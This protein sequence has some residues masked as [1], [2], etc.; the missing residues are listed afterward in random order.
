M[1]ADSGEPAPYR[2]F[3]SYSHVDSE[4]AHW[5][6]RKLENY[7]L[8]GADTVLR[9][10]FIDSAEL[11]A[12]TDLTEQVR[13]ALGRSAALIVAAS[14]AAHG[15]R[16]VAQEIEL[17]RELHPD[18]PILIAL[19]EGEPEQAFP[20]V[21][22]SRGGAAVEPLAADFRRGQDG[23]RLGLLKL[24][25][26]LTGTPL[27]R[28][29][30]RDGQRRQ[31]RVMA[32]TA[33]TM[34][35]SLIL[36]ALLL[37]AIRARAEAERR[38]AETEGMVEFMLTDLRQKLESVGRLDI[39]GA[40]N[41]RAMGHYAKER[42]LPADTM[43][44][45]ARLLAAMGEDDLTKTG[46]AERG[47]RE[48]SQAYRITGDLLKSDP[49]NPERIYQHA[50]SEHW[51]GYAAYLQQDKVTA[52]EH[53]LAYRA[54]IE[55]LVRVTID[56]QKWQREVAY[57]EGDLCAN[58]LAPPVEHAKALPHC[59]AA[60]E[61]MED[62]ALANP[63]NVETML[64]LAN[65]YAWQADALSGIGKHAEALALRERQKEL[66][67]RAVATA[68]LDAQAKEALMRAESGLARVLIQLSRDQDASAAADRAASIA[69]D[70]H[71]RDPQNRN[72]VIWKASIPR[73]R[74]RVTP[75][76]QVKTGGL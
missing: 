39:M 46:A 2:A 23:R 32:V 12:G 61:A 62:V 57:A 17:F 27:D 34:L 18:A 58:A 3:V 59:G 26:G 35:L 33:F 71:R 16:W 67:A 7:R 30:Q 72:W 74:I 52:A 15:S 40:V 70:L 6:H 21:L 1:P 63:G 66:V 31:R 4:F 51:Q 48:F 56:K 13:D 25:A 68:P 43:A 44:R 45:R 28:L 9:P 53:F 50:Q 29:V 8:P 73:P 42:D 5:L 36:M 41:E 11:V 10:L 64:D 60:R 49:T 75:R 47:I 65:R 22:R 20:K 37:A 24:V 55:R 14:P 69:D 76:K 54:L 38:R 19:H